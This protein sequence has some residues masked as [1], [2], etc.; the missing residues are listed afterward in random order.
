MVAMVAGR[1]RGGDASHRHAAVDVL[2][3]GH[4]G[5]GGVCG[6]TPQRASW[7]GSKNPA[8][9]KLQLCWCVQARSDCPSGPHPTVNKLDI[10]YLCRMGSQPAGLNLQKTAKK[11]R[12]LMSVKSSYNAM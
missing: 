12:Q 10:L 2:I 7:K 4:Q 1:W 11:P 6:K 9:L 8:K 3:L 5:C